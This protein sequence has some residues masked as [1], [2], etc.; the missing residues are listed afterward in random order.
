[1]ASEGVP[2]NSG[3]KL[4]KRTPIRIINRAIAIKEIIRILSDLRIIL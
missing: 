2:P 4:T 1:L 3:L